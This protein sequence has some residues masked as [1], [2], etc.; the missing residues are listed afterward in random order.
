[1]LSISL[2]VARITDGSL[3]N[4]KI[5]EQKSSPGSRWRFLYSK[6]GAACAR[7][8]EGESL[9]VI[10]VT[11]NSIFGGFLFCVTLL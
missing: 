2:I 7:Y 5:S 4:N 10:R 9:N 8:V 3:D 11:D 6:A 1:M